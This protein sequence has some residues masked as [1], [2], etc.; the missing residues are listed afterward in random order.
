MRHHIATIIYKAYFFD[1]TLFDSSNGE[2]IP[3]VLGDSSWP[4]GL[5]N[6]IEHMR[7]NEKAKIKIQK[8]HAFGRKE[9]AEKLRFPTGYEVEGEKRERLL[10][11]G[12]IY[13]V[14]L[15]DWIERVD[16]ESDGNFLK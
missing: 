2:A 16:L 11:K 15:I 6:G 14:K 10:K 5:W 4:E 13:E 7:K 1:H 9:N 12:V 8:K 3:F